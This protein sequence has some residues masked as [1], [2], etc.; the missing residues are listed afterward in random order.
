[1]IERFASNQVPEGLAKWMVHALRPELKCSVGPCK[2]CWSI[3][4]SL[5][6]IMP[7]QWDINGNPVPHEW[8]RRAT[9]NVVSEYVRVLQ[10]LETTDKGPDWT[11]W[12][13]PQQCWEG[14]INC[15][16]CVQLRAEL[17]ARTGKSHW[18]Q[19]VEELGRAEGGSLREPEFLVQPSYTGNPQPVTETV[20]SVASLDPAYWRWD[21]RE[22]RQVRTQPEIDGQAS[23][24]HIPGCEHGSRE[25]TESSLSESCM[26]W[27][28]PILYVCRVRGRELDGRSRSELYRP[29]TT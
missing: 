11:H 25:D 28:Q 16:E 6:L 21:E 2:E 23:I 18:P 12:T 10:S 4:L 20:P 5:A 22:V 19:P 9:H 27:R 13:V 29:P 24:K 17:S 14:Q 3:N 15:H 1:M 7:G 26:D 8:G